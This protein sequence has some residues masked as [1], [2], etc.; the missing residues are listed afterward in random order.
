MGFIHLH[1]P[2]PLCIA[3]HYSLFIYEPQPLI[4]FPVL[5]SSNVIRNTIGLYVV[6]LTGGECEVA[7]L[8]PSQIIFSD[9]TVERENTAWE[10]AE[11][12]TQGRDQCWSDT[13]M[14]SGTRAQASTQSQNGA[15][16]NNCCEWIH[17]PG[18]PMVTGR[19]HRCVISLARLFC[20]LQ[21]YSWKKMNVC[22]FV[23]K[24]PYLMYIID[25]LTLTLWPTAL[26]LMPELSLFSPMAPY[27]AFSY[28]GTLDSTSPLYFWTI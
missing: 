17:S 9:G 15:Q 23:L 24:A 2:V 21:Q 12:S 7:G 20:S 26:W 5:M 28:L 25:S 11:K 4:S 3:L 14:R 10:R 8:F 13:S 27:P 6:I 22:V 19:V 18:R 16:S 1:G